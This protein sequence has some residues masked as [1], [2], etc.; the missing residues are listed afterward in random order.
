MELLKYRVFKHAIVSTMVVSLTVCSTSLFAAAVEMPVLLKEQK[1]EKVEPQEDPPFVASDPS[2]TVESDTGI[3]GMTMLYIGG[4]IGLV[5]VG[6][7]ALSGGSGSSSDSGG[8]PSLPDNTPPPETPIVGPDLN[9]SNWAG[10]LD[11]VNDQATGYQNIAA[12]IVHKGASVQITT[13]STLA[14]GHYFSGRISSGGSMKMY[15]STTGEDWTTYSSRA[16]GN[17]IDLYDFVNDLNN[18]EKDRMLLSR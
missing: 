4:A 16:T 3:D 8:S 18:N 12:S 10:F 1:K 17:R 11:L 2:V 9:G 15:D 14:Y 6:A 5:A 7:L 13:T